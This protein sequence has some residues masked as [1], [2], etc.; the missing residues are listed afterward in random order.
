MHWDVLWH[1]VSKYFA[2]E[3]QSNEWSELFAPGLVRNV[4]TSLADY[5][6]SATLYPD[7]RNVA[8]RILRTIAT[9]KL[10]WCTYEYVCSTAHVTLFLDLLNHIHAEQNVK[11]FPFLA[12]SG[13][14][15]KCCATGSFPISIHDLITSH[16]CLFAIYHTHSLTSVT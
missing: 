14:S 16:K 7:D 1:N 15:R 11:G 4:V 3:Q 8:K 10:S 6:I 5:R 12:L 9:Q 2:Y 13:T